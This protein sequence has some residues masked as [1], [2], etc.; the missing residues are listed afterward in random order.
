MDEEAVDKQRFDRAWANAQLLCSMP[1]VA[2][3]LELVILLMH[4]KIMSECAAEMKND[5]VAHGEEEPDADS[6]MV[7]D[8]AVDHIEN[9]LCS[10][11]LEYYKERFGRYLEAFGVKRRVTYEPTYP[12]N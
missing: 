11:N 8:M 3:D 1:G 12:T 10:G 2:G 9:T 6:R 5:Y 4:M 7:Y